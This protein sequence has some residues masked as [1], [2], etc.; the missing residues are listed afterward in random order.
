MVYVSLFRGQTNSP[1]IRFIVLMVNGQLLVMV[2]LFVRGIRFVVRWRTL[3]FQIRLS[4]ILPSLL[5]QGRLFPVLTVKFRLLV[6]RRRC[7]SKVS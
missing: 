5:I 6:F 3:L 4:D 2:L 1:V 7:R